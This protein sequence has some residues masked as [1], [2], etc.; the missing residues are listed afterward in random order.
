MILLSNTIKDLSIK[1]A[2]ERTITFLGTGPSTPITNRS[3]K[4]N[5]KN[6]STLLNCKGKKY[7]IDVP[8]DIDL[9]IKPDYL[10][11]THLHD[12][13][14]GGFEKFSKQKIIL[15][16]PS[17]LKKNIKEKLWKKEELRIDR[18]N[19]FGDLKV[20]PFGV[21]HD[22]INK[23]VTY[24]YRFLFEDGFVLIYA[25]DMVGIPDMSEQ[26]F[27][28]VDLLITDGC[29]WN[30]N[31]PT[32]FG[33]WSFLD[34]VKEKNWDVKKI[35]FTHIGQSVPDHQEAQKEIVSRSNKAK[36]AYDGLRIIF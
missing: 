4:S 23:S 10:L 22:I 8:P 6:T 9:E 27:E 25:S 15:G 16:I 17:G 34:L 19:D 2:K 29:G 13:S 12:D 5:R 3:G 7:L 32:H 1:I 14:F 30:A 33:M 18:P 35:Y 28:K 20:T 26:Y 21:I 24:G 11:I 36:L 31:L